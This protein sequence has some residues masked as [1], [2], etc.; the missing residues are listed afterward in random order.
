MVN[1]YSKN[2]EQGYWER[3]SKLIEPNS[4]YTFLDSDLLMNV[5]I[6]QWCKYIF[7]CNWTIFIIPIRKNTLIFNFGGGFLKRID[8]IDTFGRPKL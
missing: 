5:L 3:L 1:I 4:I 2:R 6:F 8:Q 7:S